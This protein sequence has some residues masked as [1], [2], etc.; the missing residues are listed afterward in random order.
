MYSVALLLAYLWNLRIQIKLI[1]FVC[2][3]TWQQL[4][5]YTNLFTTS[6]L[7]WLLFRVIC[8][9]FCLF[10]I[11]EFHD[12]LFRKSQVCL[13][14]S[15]DWNHFNNLFAIITITLIFMLLA[16]SVAILPK[17]PITK[18]F[19]SPQPSAIITAFSTRS[20]I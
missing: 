12:W 15:N 19:L 1:S 5:F 14:R 20:R 13:S 11:I 17:P 10:T 16:P 7:L 2:L 4:K 18:Y 9:C 6:I 3:K 8:G